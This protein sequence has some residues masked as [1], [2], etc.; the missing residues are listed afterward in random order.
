VQAAVTLSAE[1]YQPGSRWR[2]QH[3]SA[4]ADAER[5]RR[6]PVRRQQHQA[7]QRRQHK[8]TGMHLTDVPTTEAAPT[9]TTTLLMCT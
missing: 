3:S 5:A 4:G 9:A 2:R 7:A 1:V 8:A 6:Q